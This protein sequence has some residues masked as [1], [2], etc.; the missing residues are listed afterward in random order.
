MK[1]FFGTMV[2]LGAIIF[3]APM[4]YEHQQAN[5]R[6]HLAEAYRKHLYP[7]DAKR[8]EL[9]RHYNANAY[10]TQQHRVR[11]YHQVTIK[12]IM[13]GHP[14]AAIGNITI[15]SIKLKGM[16][17]YYGDSDRVLAKGTGVMPFTSLPAKG[18]YVTSSV[19]GHTG[20][21]NKIFFDNIRYM[22]KGDVFYLDVFAHRLAYKVYRKQVIDPQ[23]PDAV[24][25]FYV[26]GRQN[27]AILMTCTPIGINDH[28]LLVYGKQVPIKEAEQTHTIPRDAF[29]P[30]NLWRDAI[31]LLLVLLLLW[32]LYRWYQ[33]HRDKKRQQGAATNTEESA[34]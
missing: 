11:P 3:F 32:W 31:I 23:S 16:P 20:M 28:R 24:S 18:H 1:W 8:D 2:V 22:K 34:D 6:M 26:Q 33:D 12:Q 21:A 4:I 5:Q 13:N 19:T 14:H 7:A 10:A 30:M 29:S 25:H 15:P 9:I 27:R 17:I